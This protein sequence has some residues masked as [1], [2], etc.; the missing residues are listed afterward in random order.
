MIKT[1]QLFISLGCGGKFGNIRSTDSEMREE[2]K[3]NPKW[4]DFVFL[5]CSLDLLMFYRYF[6]TLIG[7][8]WPRFW[9]L[10]MLGKVL[11]VN[12]SALAC[13]CCL[14]LKLDRSTVS[15]TEGEFKLCAHLD[16]RV[17]RNLGFIPHISVCCDKP[18]HLWAECV[19]PCVYYCFNMPQFY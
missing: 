5:F 19:L 6:M 14:K 15:G 18:T 13:K 8:A 12:S 11:I 10:V 4:T 9:G 7:W 2:I 16:T 3:K 1:Q 17:S